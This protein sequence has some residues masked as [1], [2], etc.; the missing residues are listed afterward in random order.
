MCNARTLGDVVH[1]GLHLALLIVLQEKLQDFFGPVRAIGQKSK[2]G[3][4]FLRASMPTLLLREL[5]RELD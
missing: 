2:V 5:I 3:E 4:R 1:T